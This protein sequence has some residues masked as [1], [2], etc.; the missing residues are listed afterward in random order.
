MRI[1]VALRDR[2]PRVAALFWAGSLSARVVGVITWRTHLVEDPEALALIDA[3]VAERATNWGALSEHKLDD[4]IDAWIA[5]FDPAALRHTENAERARDFT[6]G[7]LDDP[8]GVTSVWGRLLATDAAVAKR[9]IAD[10]VAGVCEGDPRTMGQRRSDAV[11]AILAG[12]HTL[13][14]E[15]QSEH[16][17]SLGAPRPSNVVVHVMAEQAVTPSSA[18]PQNPRAA[19]SADRRRRRPA[20]CVA[21]RSDPRRRQGDTDQDARR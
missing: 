14:C 18:T 19:G 13:V 7:D 8:A 3:A 20:G 10:M 1:A 15:C 21:D 6:I 2:L 4:A 11:G 9:R 12:A 17:P 16:C 5:R